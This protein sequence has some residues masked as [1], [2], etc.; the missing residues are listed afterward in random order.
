MDAIRL[1]SHDGEYVI[2]MVTPPPLRP[3][4]EAVRWRG[5]CFVRNPAGQYCEVMV[6][7]A[8]EPVPTTVSPDE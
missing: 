8:P 4:V 7:T 5:R 6:W 2:G 3:P 1:L